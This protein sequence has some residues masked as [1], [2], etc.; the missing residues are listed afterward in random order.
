MYKHYKMFSTTMSIENI[1]N[2]Y[3]TLIQIISRYNLI[4]Y[5]KNNIFNIEKN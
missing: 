3:Y 5:N 1:S 4:K 2:T